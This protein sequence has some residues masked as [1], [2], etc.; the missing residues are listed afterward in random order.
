MRDQWY[1]DKRDIIKWGVLLELARRHGARHILQVLYYRPSFYESLDID[2][3]HCR[4]PAPVL[5]H[6]RRVSTVSSIQCE[7]TV[8]VIK[9]LFERR[10]RY[11]ALVLKRMRSRPLV[12]G[13]VFLDPD[14]GLAPR[15]PRPKHVLDKELNAI[16]RELRTG[17]LLVFYQHQTNRK[18]APWI[19]EKRAQFER[20]IGLAPGASKVAWAPSIAK[21]VVFFFAKKGS[22]SE[23]RHASQ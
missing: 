1:G 14:T 10:G 9:E 15:H 19:D 16:S 23:G 22:R 5:H 4:V 17:D 18:G 20:A 21:D 13:I 12:P 2:G 6:F 8:E 11:L 7:A 3:E